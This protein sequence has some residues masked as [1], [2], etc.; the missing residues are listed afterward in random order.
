MAYVWEPHKTETQGSQ[1]AML[2]WEEG[3][4]DW[5]FGGREDGS[6]EDGSA[7]A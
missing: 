5:G 3:G 2:S 4:G 1:A 7:N 6:Q